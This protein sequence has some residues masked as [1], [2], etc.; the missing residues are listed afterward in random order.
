MAK[1]E[2]SNFS[3]MTRRIGSTTYKVKVVFNENGTE[4]MEDKI[5]R[6]I[7]NEVITTTGTCDIIN[8]PQMSRQSERSAS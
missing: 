6:L 4:T 2:N 5:L 3:Y 1:S 8:A 7:R